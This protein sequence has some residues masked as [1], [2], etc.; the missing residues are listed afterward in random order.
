MNL[1]ILLSPCNVLLC[2]ALL[3]QSFGMVAPMRSRSD[4][5]LT[6]ASARGASVFIDVENARGAS[7]FELSHSQILDRATLW[8]EKR[9]LRGHVSLICDHGSEQSAYWL[10]ERGLTVIF[11]G[12]SLKADDVIARDVAFC[13]ESLMSDVVVVTADQELIRRCRRAAARSGG[14]ALQIV[15][16]MNFLED[17][18]AITSNTACTIEVS[19]G[20]DADATRESPSQL[21]A[22]IESKME[23]E[24]SLMG[25]IIEAETQLRRK[26]GSPKKRQKLSK[27]LHG[28]KEKLA[29]L[30]VGSSTLDLVTGVRS[31]RIVGG[32][33]AMQLSRSE[34]DFL[35]SR[36]ESHRGNAGRKEKTGDRIVLAER[37]R[38]QL[39]TLVLDASYPFDPDDIENK[40][41]ARSHAEHVNYLAS[42]FTSLDSGL[43]SDPHSGCQNSKGN[44]PY[45]KPEESNCGHSPLRLTIIA[46]TH[47]YESSLTDVGAPDPWFLTKDIGEEQT[48]EARMHSSPKHVGGLG[49]NDGESLPDGDILLHLGDFA[50]DGPDRQMRKALGKFDEWLSRQPHAHKIVLRGN[51]D[52]IDASFPISGAA[53]VKDPTKLCINELTFFLVP[54]LNHRRIKI[55]AGADVLAT[56]VPPKAVLDRCISG[57]L[58][59]SS[60]LRSGVEKMP[61]RPPL[62]WACGHIHEGRGSRY[63]RFGSGPDFHE[64]LVLNAANANPGR[65]TELVN[66]PVILE[67]SEGSLLVPL[68]E[69]RLPKYGGQSLRRSGKELKPDFELPAD[70]GQLLLA[71]DLGLR[72][73]AS[74]FDEQ[75][76]L[77]WYEQF[78]YADEE[79]LRQSAPKLIEKLELNV[80]EN[81]TEDSKRWLVTHVVVEGGDAILLDA[82]RAAVE[83]VADSN[84][85]DSEDLLTSTMRNA[86]FLLNIKAEEWRAELLLPKE[87]KST[88]TAKAAARLI[89]RQVVCDCGKKE[90]HIGKFSTDAAEAVAVGFYM[91]R[92]LGWVTREPAVRRT[93]NGIVMIPRS[94]QSTR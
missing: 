65:A 43:D 19:Q 71:I 67:L 36:W 12:P 58:A 81:S 14:P 60:A 16:P 44:S 51:H 80:N 92:R 94:N 50:I 82:W 34:Q 83:D 6:K 32:D 24:I 64:T 47:G 46:D 41:P 53:F 26:R 17:M 86:P 30:T 87:K 75:G 76:V 42:R 61:G 37:L 89:A 45:E 2:L 72:M 13:H 9:G 5:R 84:P 11:G 29:M 39:E 57:E 79:E 77:L 3:K 15:P 52:P 93:S 55:P 70:V 22:E 69:E 88:A 91:A 20:S 49:I 74:C 7:G 48:P 4:T 59:G 40:Y 90:R 73:G 66:G 25:K 33:L 38:R 28:L 54:Y 8:A 68:K 63:V 35:L 10:A 1:S 21:V 23:A 56:H 18:E 78:Q 62:L 31:D 27:Q 85:D